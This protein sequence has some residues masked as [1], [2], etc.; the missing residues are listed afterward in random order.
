[1]AK[2][3]VISIFHN[4]ATTAE[5]SVKSLL[6]QSLKDLKIIL[7]DDNSTDNTLSVLK[8]VSKN[9]GNVTIIEN[10]I[11]LGF[12]N[13]L[14]S[15]IE[16]VK[17]YD[18]IAIH[19]AGDIS[20]EDRLFVQ[21][22]FLEK[23][24]DVGVVA[25]GVENRP[26]NN[27]SKKEKEITTDDLLKRNCINHGTAMFRISDYAK[28]GGYRAFFTQRQDKDLWYRMS[29]VTRIYFLPN[30][31]YS[32]TPQLNSVSSETNKTLVPSLLSEFATFLIKQR[33]KLGEDSL[34]IYGD[35]AALEF[36]PSS[37]NYI[38]IRDFRY[39]FL[40]GRFEK[41]KFQLNSLKKINS[42]LFIILIINIGVS[43]LI[44]FA[45]FNKKQ[46]Q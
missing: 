30:I 43:F 41:A 26:V 27:I 3:C 18:Y 23:N 44:F 10:K 36:I 37:A 24:K 28:V 5:I 22:N 6:N 35:K 42:N 14:I 21:S 7:V 39:N 1:M 2:T 8:E 16:R 46:D 11:N 20:H 15:A 33:I 25:V 38:F 45:K 17:D 29:L 9:Y 19:G 13:S 32:W 31:L 40:R 12:T 4:R 34:D